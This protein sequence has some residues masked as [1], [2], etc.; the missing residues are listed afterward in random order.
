M[1]TVYKYKANEKEQLDYSDDGSLSQRVV[2]T[3]DNKGNAVEETVFNEKGEARYKISYTYEFD[4]NGNWTKR[5][6]KQVE[7]NGWR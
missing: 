1:R 2:Y 7:I 6:A 5:T 4:S 3:L